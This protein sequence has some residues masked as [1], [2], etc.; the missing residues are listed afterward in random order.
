LRLSFHHKKKEIMIA[1]LSLSVVL[2]FLFVHS[3]AV[4]AA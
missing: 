2:F 4:H 3:F 1:R